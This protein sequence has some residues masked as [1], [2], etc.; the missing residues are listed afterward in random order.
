MVHCTITVQHRLFKTILRLTVLFAIF[1][2]AQYF[3]IICA[4]GH[5]AWDMIQ[6]QTNFD[7]AQVLLD[8][9]SMAIEGQ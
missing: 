3:S 8:V 7:L 5:F 1:S 2:I 4:I 9:V 6:V